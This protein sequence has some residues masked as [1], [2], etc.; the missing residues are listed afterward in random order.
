MAGILFIPIF[1]FLTYLCLFVFVSNYAELFSS[2]E[3]PGI[4]LYFLIGIPFCGGTLPPENEIYTYG[5][6]FLN[7]IFYFI[8]LWL[9]TYLILMFKERRRSN[10]ITG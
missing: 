7:C 4:I 8:L 6:W 3:M 10:Q 1:I 2:I 5:T 9:I